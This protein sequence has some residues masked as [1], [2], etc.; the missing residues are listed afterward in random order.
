MASMRDGRLSPRRLPSLV[1]FLLA[2]ALG[3]PSAGAQPLCEP[4][5]EEMSAAEIARHE[6]ELRE[7]APVRD[8]ALARSVR[9]VND[10]RP[11]EVA[12][13]ARPAGGG[14]PA[15][16]G[17]PRGYRRLQCLLI[18]MQ[19]HFIWN[20]FPRDRALAAIVEGCADAGS[21]LI[22]CVRDLAVDLTA[23]AE[24]RAGFGVTNPE[25]FRKL[26]DDAFL[27]NLLHEFGH[28]VLGHFAR[29]ADNENYG[30]METEADTYALIGNVLSGAS[31]SGSASAFAI[32]SMV[33]ARLPRGGGGH[34]RF[35]CRA[36][37]AFDVM[38]ALYIPTNDVANWIAET[39]AEYLAR[40]ADPGVVSFDRVHVIGDTNGCNR[41]RN[42]A[43]AAVRRDLDAL[44]SLLDRLAQSG[45]EGREARIAAAEAVASLPLRTES[46]KRLKLN[47]AILALRRI[48][49]SDRGPPDRRTLA[50]TNRL[51]AH[52]ERMLMQSAA[53]GWLLETSAILT[54]EGAPPG[55]QLD[56][57]NRELRAKLLEAESYRPSSRRIALRLGLLE[58]MDGRCD[59]A[60]AYFG[61]TADP[62]ASE[63]GAGSEAAPF[64]EAMRR[65]GCIGA[66]ARLRDVVR[67]SHR[68]R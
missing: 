2:L 57:L 45:G 30:R 37:S 16:I 19:F 53:Y 43:I 1:F 13:F 58:L 39:P 67:G 24:G 51:L 60:L 6:L 25:D 12:P 41:E 31:P 52:P 9:I 8:A 63:S 44:I 3:A 4:Y 33:D 55:R 32:L 28:I 29:R 49:Q 38:R 47:T 11:G 23:A 15:T 68:W 21:P 59:A 10:S 14:R 42:P 34:G 20:T 65:L 61:R 66:R 18:Q 48:E 50:L 22:D 36:L 46:A 17:V 26:V 35:A 56:A 40:R 7:R 64:V 27:D 62:P 5:G 54:Y